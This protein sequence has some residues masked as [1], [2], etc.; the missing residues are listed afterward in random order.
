MDRQVVGRLTTRSIVVAAAVPPVLLAAVQVVLL[1][2]ALFN[3]NPFWR[4]EPLTLSEAAA[5][6][7]AA[8]VVRLIEAGEDPNAVYEV[9][10]GILS[11][12]AQQLTPLEAA[13]AAEREEI[14]A[15]LVAAGATARTP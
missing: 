13:A 11:P 15:L 4:W 12:A 14:T 9:R 2:L 5:L 3:A 8:E 7:D 6:R 1:V 10:P